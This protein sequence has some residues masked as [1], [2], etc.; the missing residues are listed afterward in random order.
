MGSGFGNPR[1]LRNVIRVPSKIVKFHLA[2]PSE[3]CETLTWQ[4]RSS[5]T[6]ST[7]TFSPGRRLLSA[8]KDC[9][10]TYDDL[11]LC[12]LY[13]DILP[14]ETQLETRLAEGIELHLP[15]LSSDMDTVTESRMAIAMAQHGAWA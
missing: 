13:S 5:Q 6:F 11:S 10:L 1:I 2:S 9:G 4:T 15:I 14:R 3:L 12:T 8:H 7:R